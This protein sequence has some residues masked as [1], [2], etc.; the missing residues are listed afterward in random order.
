MTTEAEKTVLVHLWQSQQL[1]TAPFKCIACISMPGKHLLEAGCIESYNAQMSDAC[2]QAKYYGV[3]IGTCDSCGMALQSNFVIRDANGKHFVVG[4]DCANKTH[5]TKV[6]TEV[7]YLE[8]KRQDVIKATKRAAAATERQRLL[9]IER[10]AQRAR[11]GGLTDQ[12]VKEQA[13]LDQRLAKVAV[14]KAANL[15]LIKVLCEVPYHSDFLISMRDSLD[16]VLAK[17]LPPKCVAILSDVYAKT[18]TGGGRRGSKEYNAAMDDFGFK[19][20]HQNFS[21]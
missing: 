12:Q 4:C 9:E 14:M 8:K 17:D 11:N 10:D 3:G 6:M 20:E 18:V 2:Q 5:D 13:E 19:I 1:G 15:W 7:K 16:R 21:A